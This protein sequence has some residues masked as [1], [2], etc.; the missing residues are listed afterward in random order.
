MRFLP[1]FV[2]LL[3]G[4]CSINKVAA[5]QKV[6]YINSEQLFIVMP[7]MKA[8]EATFQ[9]FQKQKQ[10][11]LEQM[12]AELQKKVASYQEKYKTLSEAN[13]E[14]VEKELNVLGEDIESIRKRLDEKGQKAQQ[15]VQEKQEQLYAPILKK[16][17]NAIK[18]A[19]KEK[20]YAYVFDVAQPGIVHFEGDNLLA[21]V[22]LKL[23]IQ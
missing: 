11:Q 7:E 12:D 19:A 18:S 13:R 23:G 9:T 3:C 1:L 2:F 4:L 10:L 17:Q 6:A 20:G 8:A 21:T 16:A 14:V 22:K 5:Q 15:E